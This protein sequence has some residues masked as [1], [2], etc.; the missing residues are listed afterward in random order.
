MSILVTI[1]VFFIIPALFRVVGKLLGI[2]NEGEKKDSH[3]ADREKK[4]SRP[5][6]KK[7]YCGNSDLFIP[8]DA[9]PCPACGSPTNDSHHF[10]AE[11]G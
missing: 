9:E 7:L 8:A 6:V 2:D 3:I 4:S 5:G 1:I 10:E 11:K